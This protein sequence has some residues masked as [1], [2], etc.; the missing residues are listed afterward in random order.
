MRK[1]KSSRLVKGLPTSLENSTK[2]YDDNEPDE[3]EQEIGENENESSTDVHNNSTDGMTRIPEITAEELRTEI[4]KLKKGKSPD[5]NG[6]RAEDIKACDEETKELVRQIFNEIIRQNE[7]TPEARKKVKIKVLHKK[8]D[9]ENVG[10]YRPIRSLLA[11]YKLFSTILYGRLYPRLDQEQAEY[12]TG[13]RSS[14]QTTDHLATYRMIEQKCHEW[15]IKMWIATID[16]TKAFD[17]ITHKSIWSALNSCGIN[18]EYISLLKKSYKDQRAS[19]QTDVESN[20]FE[21][22]KGTQQGDLLASLLFNTVLQSSLKE[23]TQRW[24]K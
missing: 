14:Y 13:F 16:F 2:I 15:S 23:V 5:S 1:E 6:V 12:Q 3:S 17:S 9:V 11:L 8:G 21:I 18:H 4:N 22:K 20:M 7:F 19:V 24:Q 10:Y